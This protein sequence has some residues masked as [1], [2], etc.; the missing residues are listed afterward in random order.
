MA[1]TDAVTGKLPAGT[2]QVDTES[3]ELG[4]GARGMFGLVPVHGSF[5]K[6]DGTLK[7]DGAGP[8][9]ELRIEAASLDTHNVK[10]D[11]HLLSADFFD[12]EAHPT[13]TFELTALNPEPDSTWSLSGVLRIRENALAITTP[14]TVAP[15]GPNRMTL[16]AKL[17]V[18]RTAAGVGWSKLGMIRG[19]AHLSA[20]LA[21]TKQ[22]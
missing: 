11:Q 13:V 2:W 7:V 1:T 10:R 14:V 17:S 8:R 18:D 19:Q 4:F 5:G 22:D 12:A 6:F 3:S 16:A 21:L 9:G 20:K 15:D